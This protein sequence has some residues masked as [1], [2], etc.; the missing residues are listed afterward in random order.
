ME[1]R[2][3]VW[4]AETIAI[5]VCGSPYAYVA[6]D[7]CVVPLRLSDFGQ[8]SLDD[9]LLWAVDRVGGPVFILPANP[10]PDGPR[11]PLDPPRPG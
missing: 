7:S 1:L 10:R 8:T 4:D 6:Q 9:V 2:G 3:Y 11:P 5:T